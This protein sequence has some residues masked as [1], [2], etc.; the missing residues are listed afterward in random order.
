MEMNCYS[1]NANDMHYI[2]NFFCLRAE[3]SQKEDGILIVP[4]SLHTVFG[5][6]EH[7]VMLQR[8]NGLKR[9]VINWW[10]R[11]R[12]ADTNGSNGY[13]LHQGIHVSEGNGDLS[14][15]RIL[16]N[17]IYLPSIW[18]INAEKSHSVMRM[19][20]WYCQHPVWCLGHNV[21]A[22]LVICFSVLDPPPFW[23]NDEF[24]KIKLNNFSCRNQQQPMSLATNIFSYTSLTPQRSPNPPPPP[25]PHTHT[26]SL[27][28][29]SKISS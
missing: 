27:N 4:P 6:P 2:S 28:F 1:Q 8:L 3:N 5:T 24:D 14:L 20:N 15:Q 26:F 10:W 17:Y 25:P 11:P 16:I 22:L 7:S 13:C 9:R 21:F 19:V 12:C 18:S 29:T 23:R